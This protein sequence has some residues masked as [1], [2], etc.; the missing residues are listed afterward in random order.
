MTKN[1]IKII[2]ILQIQIVNKEKKQ[3]KSS[4]FSRTSAVFVD[5]TLVNHGGFEPT[6]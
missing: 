5:F 6:V 2:Y 3:R 1:V 4:A